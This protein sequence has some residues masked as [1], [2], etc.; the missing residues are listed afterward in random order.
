MM[1]PI[2]HRFY[3][4]ALAAIWEHKRDFWRHSRML[5]QADGPS[6]KGWHKA[7]RDA[8]RRMMRN[9]LEHAKELRHG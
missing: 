1:G 5:E 3:A 2:G 6:E 7:H 4:Q 8:A 9:N